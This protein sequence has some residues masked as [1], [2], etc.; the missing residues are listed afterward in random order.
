MFEKYS[1]KWNGCMAHAAESTGDVIW[2]VLW[3]LSEEEK[4]T[5][6]M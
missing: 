4:E 2:G 6:Y 5:L 3:E 1:P